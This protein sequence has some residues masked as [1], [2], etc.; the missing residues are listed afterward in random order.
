PN[1]S[2]PTKVAFTIFDDVC[3]HHFQ[4]TGCCEKCIKR[5]PRDCV[6]TSD[7][8]GCVDILRAIAGKGCTYQQKIA[9]NLYNTENLSLMV[10][11]S[12][13]MRN[14]VSYALFKYIL[15]YLL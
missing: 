2:K 14:V 12:D 3:H 1:T 9:V 11:R 13:L 6:I 15:G 7:F 8:K 10:E 4:S 5:I